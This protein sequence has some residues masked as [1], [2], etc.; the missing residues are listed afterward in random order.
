MSSLS[1]SCK[2]TPT[3][4]QGQK[5]PAPTSRKRHAK[6]GVKML[7]GSIG[8]VTLVAGCSLPHVA[9]M[10]SNRPASKTTPSPKSPA[11]TAKPS[12]TASPVAATKVAASLATPGGDLSNGSLTRYLDAGSRKLVVNY[13]I[14]QDPAQ[15][16][17]TRSTVL[18]LAAH[19][20]NG[21]KDHAVLVSDFKATLDDG[22]SVTTLV[23]DKGA[24][25]LTPPYAY[26]SALVLRGHPGATSASLI[27]KYD[28]LVQTAP[29]LMAYFRQTVIDTIHINFATPGAN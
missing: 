25:T 9:S 2:E 19:I 11:P 29:G 13:W 14:S 22:T 26:S 6:A 5:V 17:A 3:D 1:P 27:L 15:W 16:T 18:N 23:D 4:S 10:S 21:D 28:L 8:L 24:F 12:A 20:E 7:A